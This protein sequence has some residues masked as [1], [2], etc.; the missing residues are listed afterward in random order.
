MTAIARST[1][2]TIFYAMAFAF[3]LVAPA[4]LLYAR[5]YIVDLRQHGFVSTGGVFVKTVQPG[6][7]VLIDSV[8]AKDTSFIAHGALI[9]DLLPRR[10]EVRVEKEGYRPWSK[11]VRVSREEVLEFRGVFLP[12]A[13]I[14][15]R[16]LLTRAG[17]T[18]RV[19]PLEGRSE[20]VVESGKDGGPFALSLISPPGSVTLM[21]LPDVVRWQW[22]PRSEVLFA[23]RSVPER[24]R[25]YRVTFLSG[26]GAR[27]EPVTFRGLPS[28][29]SAERVWPHPTAPDEFYFSAGGA[30]FLQGR[31]SVPVAIA[32]QLHSWAV[33]ENRLFFVT[34]NGFFAES[35]LQGGDTRLLGRKGLLLDEASPA[36]MI[37][38]PGGEVAVLDSASGL[39][40]YRTGEPELEFIAGGVTGVDF[41][42]A[43]DRLLYW[44]DH[45][46]WMYWIRD[47][48]AQPFDIAGTKKQLFYSD[49][50]IQRA[51]L[52]V[53]G[54]HAFYATEQGIRM[55]EVDDRATVNNYNLASG[56]VDSFAFDRRAAALSWFS[57][58]TLFRAEVK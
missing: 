6:T 24:L 9:T 41:A 56:E 20:V 30:L 37:I 47:N 32:E 21:T 3:A 11:L 17:P 26:G 25:W 50:P 53:E 35:N 23:A 57:G 43:R 45:R 33:G 55:T 31:S 51:Y 46:L 18:R 40:L 52:N 42:S 44:D 19:F 48:S 7:K 58:P 15:P 1:R 13:T 28:G 16:V 2:R 39:F 49:S 8:F 22:D 38:G 36:A 5:G 14:T 12:P 10:Y 34:R 54:T 27:A 4:I 29:F